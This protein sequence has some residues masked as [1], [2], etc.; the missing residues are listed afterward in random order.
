MSVNSFA[1]IGL[2]AAGLLAVLALEWQALATPEPSASTA[3]AAHSTPHASA[4]PT[5]DGTRQ[6]VTKV[7]ER[8]LFSASRRPAAR[9][10][11]VR[12]PNGP[13]APP[14]LSGILVSREG[15][16]AIFAGPHKPIA[17]REGGRLADYSVRLIEPNRVILQGSEGELVVLP[18]FARN[19][20]VAAQPPQI[21]GG[22]WRHPALVRLAR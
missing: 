18:S 7:L 4:P 5:R 13:A 12:L 1:T 16:V 19:R 22:S 20:S 8:P 9:R 17:L 11:S 21:S 2:V 6:W 15:K 14:R 10:A 3:H